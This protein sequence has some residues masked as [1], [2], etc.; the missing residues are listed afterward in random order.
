MHATLISWMSD[1]KNWALGVQ[2]ENQNNHALGLTIRPVR[3][4]PVEYR[5]CFVAMHESA[6]LGPVG[7]VCCMVAVGEVDIEQAERHPD[8]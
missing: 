7:H 5:R 8:L 4:R 2:H 3:R 6:Q 1:G